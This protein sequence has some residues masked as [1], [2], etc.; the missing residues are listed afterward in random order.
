MESRRKCLDYAVV[1][2][3]HRLVAPRNRG[4]YGF[5]Y[6]GERVKLR[7]LRMEVEFHPLLRSIIVPCI[8]DRAAFLDSGNACKYKFSLVV[9][10]LDPA[11]DRYIPSDLEFGSK[12]LFLFVDEYLCRDRIRIIRHGKYQDLYACPGRIEFRA[13][14]LAIYD[15]FPH[16]GYDVGNRRRRAF[17][18][19]S[20]DHALVCCLFLF[21][22]LICAGA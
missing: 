17:E 11:P 8:L 15:D 9:V 6:I 16:L 3:G 5:T 1:C 19:T 20:V 12:I 10:I 21:V 22:L 18:L 13:E 2:D 4:F 7:K 14:D